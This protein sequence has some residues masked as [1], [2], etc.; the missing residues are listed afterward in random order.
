MQRFGMTTRVIA[1]AL[2]VVIA[3]AALASASAQQEPP[4]RYFGHGATPGDVI[5]LHDAMGDEIDSDTVDA[6]GSWYIDVDRDKAEGVSF[7]V[8]GKAADANTTPAGQGQASVVLTVAMVEES[9]DDSTT[10]ETDGDSMMEESDDS[11]ME[12]DDSMLEEDSDSMMDEG[13]DS[14]MEDDSMLDED[15][16]TMSEDEDS[17]GEDVGMPTTGTGG[18][19]D[20]GISA[21]LIGLL[22][23]LGAAAVAGLGIR[24]VRNRA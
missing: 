20:G 16:S 9:D 19:A 14:M 1:V 6:D 13:D 10:E 21:G 18:L 22:I 4:Y 15:D 8:N 7:T 11:M 12:D 3:I 17:M 23:A 24:R 5:A 2:G